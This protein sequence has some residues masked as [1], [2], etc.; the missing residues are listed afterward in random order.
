MLMRRWERARQG[1]GQL[2]LIIGEP[3]LGKSR[4]I[5]EFHG[6]L[7]DTPHTWVEWS[8]SQLLQNT[9]LHPV[10]EWGHQRFGGTE[11][12]AERRLADLEN[13]LTLTK[14]DPAENVPLLAPLL[15]MPLPKERALTLAPEELRGRQ[16]GA[17]KAGQSRAQGFSRWWWRSRTCI[18]PIRRRSMCCAALPNVARWRL[19]S[20]WRR[21]DRSSG[22]LGAFGRI[23]VPSR[24]R[25]LTAPRYSTW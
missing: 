6:R 24:S 7:R 8:C 14:L 22:H 23:T 1:D 20:S 4:L 25:R 13:T 10:T 18:G 16:F 11:V 21:R 2:V 15:D 9:P 5:D 19:C 3:G 12:P 17:L